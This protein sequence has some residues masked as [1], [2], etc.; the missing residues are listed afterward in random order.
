MLKR[1]L[2]N[3]IKSNNLR[4]VGE[5]KNALKKKMRLAKGDLVDIKGDW[6]R[7]NFPNNTK[8][9]RKKATRERI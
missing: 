3:Y 2:G 6:Y 7:K 8:Y 4:G 9:E 5:R 1:N